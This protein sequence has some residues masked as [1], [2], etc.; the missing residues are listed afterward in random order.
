MGNKKTY[1]KILETYQIGNITVKQFTCR[2]RLLRVH[3]KNN[4]LM[5]Q[6]MTLAINGKVNVY[7]LSLQSDILIF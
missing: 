6:H 1:H 5:I 4:Y 7:K 3:N 2:Y